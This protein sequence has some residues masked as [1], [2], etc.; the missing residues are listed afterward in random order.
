MVINIKKKVWG[1][2][3]SAL[4]LL[5]AGLAQAQPVCPVCTVAV[6][7]GLGLA[8]WFKIDDT[9]TGVWVAGLIIAVIV[10]TVNFM[11]KKNWRFKGRS[12]VV[13][14]FYYLSVIIPL[15]IANMIGDPLNKFC[16]IDKLIF[17]ISC[18]SIIF[19]FALWLHTY[20]KRK[21]N[22]KSYFPYQKVVLPVGSLIILSFVLYLLIRYC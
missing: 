7:T 15:Y 17:G 4:A 12:L 14:S 3:L 1:A 2:I 10:W 22:G 21:N 6:F 5:P 19:V 11:D 9:I 8:R 16:G 18:G 20:L 13:A